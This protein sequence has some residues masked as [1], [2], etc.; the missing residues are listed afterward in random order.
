MQIREATPADFERIWPIFHEIVSAGD[1][2]AIPRNTTRQQ[3]LELWVQKPHK[4]FVLEKHGDILATYYIKPNHPGPGGHVCNCGY[5][6]AAKARGQGLASALCEH[7]Q[8]TALVLGYKA[9]QYNLVVSTNKVAVK[10]WEKHGFEIVGRLPKAFEH[11][12]RGYVDAFVMYK[13]L[14]AS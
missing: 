2:Y 4:T 5:M 10:L 8:Q 11:P 3:A 12:T 14:A 9:M 13:W 7:S 1:T 6:V